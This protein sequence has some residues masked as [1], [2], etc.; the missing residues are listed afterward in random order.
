MDITNPCRWRS[1]TWTSLTTTHFFHLPPSSSPPSSRTSADTLSNSESHR[2]LAR[3]KTSPTLLLNGP[4]D[5]TLNVPP[6]PTMSSSDNILL[7][8]IPELTAAL[9][10]NAWGI[11]ASSE[12]LIADCFPITPE[13][14]EAVRAEVAQRGSSARVVG[15]ARIAILEGVVMVVQLDQRGFTVRPV[16]YL[17]S[18]SNSTG[19]ETDETSRADARSRARRIPRAEITRKT[20]T[21][22][23]RRS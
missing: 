22:R 10:T 4:T 5:S 1:T 21:R 3:C 8:P 12:V 11:D 17:P 18:T 19:Y 16:F 2:H 23:S 14:V 20:R 13:D 6:D 9:R 15:K 7:N